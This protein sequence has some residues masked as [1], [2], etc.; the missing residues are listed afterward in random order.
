MSF[1]V[2]LFL[3]CGLFAILYMFIKFCIMTDNTV[4]HIIAS[5]CFLAGIILYVAGYMAGTRGWWWTV[6][7]VVVVYIIIYKLVE[8]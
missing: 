6:I 3:D 4:R 5:L 1:L 7:S 2:T 8:A